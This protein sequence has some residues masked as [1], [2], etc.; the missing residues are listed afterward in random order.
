MVPLVALKLT[1]PGVELIVQFE[2]FT[3][4]AYTDPV[5]ICT[6]GPGIVQHQGACTAADFDKWGD[7]SHPR[8]SRE[9]YYQMLEQYNEHTLN[10]IEEVVKVPLAQ[11]QVNALCS[12][13]HNIG[14]Q[15]FRDSTLLK[16]LNARDY[17]GAAEQFL[18][19]VNP[20]SVRE[21]LLRRRKAE[22]AMFLR[23]H[24]VKPVQFS[25]AEQTLMRRYSNELDT[26]HVVSPRELRLRDRLHHQAVLIRKAARGEKGG[27][28]DHDRRRRYNAIKKLLR[29]G[30]H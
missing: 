8:I 18:R 17:R 29:R 15:A 25:E 5:G 11:P 14:P 19:W 26:G 12:I 2:G 4:Y 6:A 20:P 3:N 22:M 7:R 27:W 30:D 24:V 13:I 10:L 28:E 1:R 23:G 9:R 16:K 21:G